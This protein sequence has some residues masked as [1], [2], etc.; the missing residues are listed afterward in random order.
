V[1]ESEKIDKVGYAQLSQEERGRGRY[2]RGSAKRRQR[3]E[4]VLP[5]G[6]YRQV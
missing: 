1:F 2:L 5:G 6:F 4:A 3:E